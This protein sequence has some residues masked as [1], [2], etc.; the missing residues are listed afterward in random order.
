[1][2]RFDRRAFLR[3]LSGAGGSLA[4]HGVGRPTRAAA[5]RVDAEP[6]IFY[7]QPDGQR[8]L[9]RFFVSGADAPAGRL[10]VFDRAGRLIGTAGVIPLGDGRLYGELWLPLT[11][12]ERVDSELVLPGRPPLRTAHALAPRPR[13]SLYWTTVLSPDDLADRVR[14]LAPLHR[15][16]QLGL[17]A[18][19]GVT[20]NPLPAELAGRLVDH[21]PFLRLGETS[22]D[23]ELDLGLPL[24]PVAVLP[25]PALDHPTLPLVLQGSGIRYAATPGTG[26]P[27]WLVGPDGSRVMVAPLYPGSRPAELG[28]QQGGAELLRRVERWLGSLP[29]PPANDGAALIA[30]TR[31]EDASPD[32]VR[33]VTEWNGRLAFPRILLGSAGEYFRLLERRGGIRAAP[34][35]RAPA[36]GVPS[37]ASELTSL[38]RARA[39]ERERRARAMVE[40]IGGLDAVAGQLGFGLPGTVVFNPS[41]FSRTGFVRL[42]DGT[43]RVVT[44]VPAIGYAYVPHT[45]ADEGGWRETAG[46]VLEN[47]HV[48]VSL[49]PETGAIGSLVSLPDGTEWARPGGPGLNSVEAARVER[50]TRLELAGAAHRVVIERWSPGRGAVRS[51]ITL[52]DALARVEIE[53]SV[54]AVGDA[55]P[56]Y[57]FAL[58]LDGAAV[59]WEV[60]AGVRRARAPV[61]PFAALRWI[62]LSGAPGSVLVGSLDAPFAAVTESGELVIPGPQG[63]ARFQIALRPATTYPPRDDAWRFGWS[64]EPFLTAPVTGRGNA[65]LPSFGSLLELDEPGVMILG[66]EPRGAGRV[67]VYLQ[68]VLGLGRRFSLRGGLLRFEEARVADLL[69]RPGGAAVAVTLPA[70][71]VVALSLQGVSLRRA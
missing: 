22:R 61:G 3:A 46:H 23:L 41:P 62:R 33:A 31:V 18:S 13:W 35:P 53:N 26:E 68:E 27:H 65:G 49:D 60:P 45:R 11:G 34:E 43:K 10:R 4:F 5:L 38:A 56:E 24:N 66:I 7:A 63:V 29:A 58:P 32:I 25:A 1:M 52:L 51:T 8:V 47:T 17:W 21:L 15:G 19:A 39:D 36:A 57:R 48:R 55:P 71:G 30:G 44:D 67:V 40:A 16:T 12:P 37:R 70:Y 28:F 69:G 50:I 54:E 9:V 42:T 14:G 6:T 59:E 64:S 2:R 20:I